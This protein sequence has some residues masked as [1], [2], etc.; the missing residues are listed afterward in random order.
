MQGW[1][2]APAF[3][4]RTLTAELFLMPLSK[5]EIFLPRQISLGREQLYTGGFF[6][7][8]FSQEDVKRLKNSLPDQLYD[9][10]D[11]SLYAIIL[12]DLSNISYLI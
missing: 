12:K 9:T 5:T 10:L 6:M 3:Q 11:K 7:G 4:Q 2:E 8:F 1:L